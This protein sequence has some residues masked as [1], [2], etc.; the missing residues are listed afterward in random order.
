MTISFSPKG[1]P[2]EDSRD[3]PHWSQNKSV[4]KFCGVVVK[5]QEIEMPTGKQDPSEQ[6]SS[7]EDTSV[8][9]TLDLPTLEVDDE[10]GNVQSNLSDVGEDPEERQYGQFEGGGAAART[11]YH[12]RMSDQDTV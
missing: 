12:Q 5:E 2:Q 11:V 7:D 8:R 10:M 1:L 6:S 4:Q 3:R 9:D